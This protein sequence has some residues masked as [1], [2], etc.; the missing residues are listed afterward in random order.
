MILSIMMHAGN[1]DWQAYGV[2]ASG[3][4]LSE[5]SASQGFF[6]QWLNLFQ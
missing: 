6:W 3:Q 5:P 2:L 1:T 4:K